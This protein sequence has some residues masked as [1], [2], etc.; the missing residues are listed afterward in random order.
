MIGKRI[1]K[2]YEIIRVIGDGGMSRVYLAHDIILDRDVAIKV[3]HYDFANE[4]E[5][6]KRFQREALSATSLTHP[7]IVNIF[8]VGQEDE[9]HYLVME[10]IAGKTLKDYIHTHGALSAEQAVSIMKQLVSAISHAHH[11][12]IVHRDIKPQNVLMN[13]E[14]D[15][16]ITDFGI[17]MALNSTAHTKT[18]SVIGTVHYLS[19]EQ[20]RGGM[21]TKRSDIYSLG[22]VFYELLTGQLPFSAETAVAIALKHL[23]EETPSVRDQFPEIPQSVE[24]VILKA[25]AKDSSYRYASADDM[26]DDLLTVLSQD[27]LNESKFALPFDDDKTMAIPAIK[28]ASKSTV[29]EDTMKVDPVKPEPLAPVKKKK[30][31]WPYVLAGSLLLLALLTLL[32][33]MMM[34]PKEIIVPEV[35]GEE[36][37]VAAEILE[38][39]GFVIDERFEETSDEYTAGQVIKTVPQAGKKRKEG[40][41]VKLFISAG[42]DPMVL[43]DYTGRNFEATKRFLDGYGFL[44]IESV[45]VFSDEPKGTIL[46]QQPEAEQSVIPEETKLIF[47]VSKGRELQ[48]LDDLSGMS[49][50]QLED[51]ANTS[52]LKIHIVSEEHSDKV[53][54]GYVISQKPSKGEKME[55]GQR[56]DVVV[57]KGPPSKPVKLLVKTV[58]IPYDYPEEPTVENDEDE[59]DS[60]TDPKPQ[61]EIIP[62]KVQ[63]YI[64]DRTHTMNDPMEEFE[65]TEDTTR[66]ITIELLEGERGGYKIMRDQTVIEEDKFNY[67]DLE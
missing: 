22:I 32:L 9:L 6:K 45:E 14:D 38:K 28:D 34:K 35:V 7:H 49:A 64:Q 44:P 30:K 13:G 17:A 50:K 57:S 18:N 19:P 33:V 26:Y 65:I 54:K 37:L 23:Q 39:E 21:A 62:Q 1:G 53:D 52:G 55:K 66:K 27:R 10:Y 42:K 12:G 29:I 25:T 48:S 59:I 15:V 41:G 67:A 46:S 47:T 58:T 61:S 16:K 60:E 56:V 4:E 20:A 31:K 24:N 3:L 5:L 11:N 36:E 2:R 8:D 43:S 51:Y 63:I 40:D